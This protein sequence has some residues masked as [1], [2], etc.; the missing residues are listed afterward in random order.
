MNTIRPAFPD[1]L[2]VKPNYFP[3]PQ[4]AATARASDSNGVVKILIAFLIVAV[5]G[6]LALTL[7]LNRSKESSTL[8]ESTVKETKLLDEL[9][10]IRA[11]LTRSRVALANSTAD[12][13]KM[14]VAYQTVIAQIGTPANAGTSRYASGEKSEAAKQN[15]PG[16]NKSGEQPK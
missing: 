8:V 10:Q 9:A 13:A 16:A 14:K 3:Q 11:E 7:Y 12:I 4:S 6:N 5:L 1:S 15:Q 2:P